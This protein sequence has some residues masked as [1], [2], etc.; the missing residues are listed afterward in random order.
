VKLKRRAFRKK[1]AAVDPSRLVVYDE[2]SAK[3]N[4]TRLYARSFDGQR[5]VEACPHGHWQT[6]TML[7]SLRLDGTTAAMSLEGAVDAPAFEAYVE[8]VLLPTLHA[9]DIFLLDNLQVHKSAKVKELIEGV[10]AEIWFL[11]PYSPDYSPI[12]NMWSKVK[13][14]LRKIKARTQGA[15]EDAIGVALAAVTPQDA[16]GWFMHCGYRVFIQP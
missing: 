12:E 9:G 8:Q 7:S 3:T 1:R 16:A 6:T 2:S 4:M 5:L 15:L 13:A 14:I 10:G 11:S